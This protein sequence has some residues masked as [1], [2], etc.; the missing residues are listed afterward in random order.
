MN[1]G[2]CPETNTINKL[3]LLVIAS[4]AMWALQIALIFI[5]NMYLVSNGEKYG[6]S[7]SVFSSAKR[8]HLAFF[9]YI[10]IAVC[11]LGLVSSLRQ[12]GRDGYNKKP[13]FFG[14]CICSVLAFLF[15]NIQRS[16]FKKAAGIGFG[17]L[18]IHFGAVNIFWFLCV[19]LFAIS[20]VCMVMKKRLTSAKE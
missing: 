12:L 17:M 5:K 3:S 14:S 2:N 18:K 4:S 13:R 16:V 7:L 9:A 19:V 1:T 15:I 11:A 20:I 10:L 8:D 6:I